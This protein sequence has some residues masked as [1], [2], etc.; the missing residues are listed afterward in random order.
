[1]HVGRVVCRPDILYDV[2]I[3]IRAVRIKEQRFM[4]WQICYAISDMRRGLPNRLANQFFFLTNTHDSSTIF[5]Y[6]LGE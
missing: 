2:R 6:I 5:G 3:F 1:M 4:F